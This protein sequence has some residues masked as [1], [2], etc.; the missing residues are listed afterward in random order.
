MC[1]TKVTS[2]ASF[3]SCFLLI[4]EFEHRRPN[5][6]G[7]VV[8]FSQYILIPEVSDKIIYEFEKIS[9]SPPAFIYVYSKNTAAPIGIPVY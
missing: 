8:S 3:P 6:L 9:C 5:V 2:V 7:V 4:P 1:D